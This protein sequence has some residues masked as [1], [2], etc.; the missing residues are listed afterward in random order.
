MASSGTIGDEGQTFEG[1][2]GSCKM[3]GDAKWSSLVLSGV[4]HPRGFQSGILPMESPWL[5]MVLLPKDSGGFHGIG[6]LEI[7]W[8]LITSIVDMQIKESVDFHNALH[9]FHA[10][11]GTGTAIIEAKLIQQ[12]AMLHQV[13]LLQIFGKHMTLWT[14][15]ACW[16]F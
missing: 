11:W 10:F 13:P 9:G 2:V 15:S 14:M 16:K 12:L 8:K 5:T 7:I 4:T 6:L 1:M 3:E